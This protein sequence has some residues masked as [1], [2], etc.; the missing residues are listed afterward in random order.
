MV[1]M[2]DVIMLQSEYHKYLN[3]TALTLSD[4]CVQGY[5]VKGRMS[6]N[7]FNP[8]NVITYRI[9]CLSVT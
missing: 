3:C 2:G 7:Y 8:Q 1:M 4:S 9:G 5:R 6:A